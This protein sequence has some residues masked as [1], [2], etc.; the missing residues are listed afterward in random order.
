MLKKDY[1]KLKKAKKTA[2]AI[3]AACEGAD[4]LSS[5]QTAQNTTSQQFDSSRLIVWG[6]AI[7]I[8]LLV[9]VV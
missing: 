7:A 9:L 1:D 8:L 4:D 6:T 2:A 3:S 5:V